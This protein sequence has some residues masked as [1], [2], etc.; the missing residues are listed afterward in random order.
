MIALVSVRRGGA[1]ISS[2]PSAHVISALFMKVVRFVC[3]LFC[4]SF[5][6]QDNVWA[7]NT[8]ADVLKEK[9]MITKEDY[10]SCLVL[11]VTNRTQQQGL[12]HTLAIW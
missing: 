3:T 1:S 5:M 6:L 12:S 9:G 8:L 4:L 7:G 10:H 11:L 2:I